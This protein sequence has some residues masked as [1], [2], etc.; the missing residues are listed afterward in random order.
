MVWS[1]PVREKNLVFSKRDR[2][3]AQIAGF[4][5]RR[6]SFD[7]DRSADNFQCTETWPAEGSHT[8]SAGTYVSPSPPISIFQLLPT[9]IISA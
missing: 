3:N 9:P 7:S 6:V 1:K 4:G 5:V 2:R 8:T